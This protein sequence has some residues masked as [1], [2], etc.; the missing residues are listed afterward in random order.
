MKSVVEPLE[1]NKVKVRIE[2]DDAEFTTALDEAWGT[3]AKEASLPG[4]R[5]GKVPK[6]VVKSRVDASF[7]RGEAIQTAVPRA[8][9]DAIREHEID[10][11]DQPDI[12]LDEGAEEGPVIFTATVEVRPEL[13]LEGYGSLEVTVANPHPA[14]D[15]VAD[16]IDKL[17]T[18]FGGLVDVERAVGQD[19][20]VTIN[21]VASRDGEEIA[22][23]T[24]ENYLYQVGSGGVVPELDTNLVGLEQGESSTF[25][26]AD[27][28]AAPPEADEDDA[29]DSQATIT[30][31]V[32]VLGIQERELPELTD[33]W[34][35]DATEFETVAE[36]RDDIVDRM[37]G[38]ARD[39]AQSQV[40]NELATA[41]VELVTDEVPEALVQA[42]AQEQLESMARMLSQSG[43]ELG[44]YLQMT[45]QQPDEFRAQLT[46]EGAR[47]AKV[48]L[49]LRAVAADQNLAPSDEELDE[50]LAHLAVHAEVELETARTNLADNG[51]MP[52]LRADIAK[53]KA[54]DWLIDTASI[55]DA[56]GAPVDPELLK[57]DPHDHGH[58]EHSEEDEP[59]D[60]ANEGDAAD[61]GQP[62]GADVVEDDAEIDPE[63]EA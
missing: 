32:E 42:A 56:S 15:E 28:T 29:D 39:R 1:G 21:L 57:I 27:P 44:Q 46:E 61:T 35:A 6:Q 55:T 38:Q 48:D 50:E 23:M 25:E 31:E 52:A 24:A 5:K 14:D 54:M 53:R 49:A 45:G 20:Y 51:Q 18:Q 58:D 22:G 8:Y 33:E 47:Q 59:G 63:D 30:L 37:S 41:L 2:L 17:R 4:F 40:R 62:T 36:L 16:Q 9:E 7:A 34:V 3:I 10:A 19:D 11:I 43:I 13:T 12:E 26:A 60:G